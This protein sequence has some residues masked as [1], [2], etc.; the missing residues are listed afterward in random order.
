MIFNF[1]SDFS[2]YCKFKGI[3]KEVET[4]YNTYICI[5]YWTIKE[6]NA[7]KVWSKDLVQE[8]TFQLLS[9]K[10]QYNFINLFILSRGDSSWHCRGYS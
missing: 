7:R 1:S 9:R 2:E 8:K 6:K 5:V 3:Y 4:L 10:Q